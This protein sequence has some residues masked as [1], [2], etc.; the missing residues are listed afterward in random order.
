M[1]V[2]V[3]R[4]TVVCV[5]WNSLTMAAAGLEPKDDGWMTSEVQRRKAAAV[6]VMAEAMWKKKMSH[7]NKDKTAK[8]RSEQWLW[9]HV[10]NTGKFV[11]YFLMRKYT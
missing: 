4:A 8:K 11:L 3:M 7:T 6:I 10:R 5:V 2:A 9:Y 1:F